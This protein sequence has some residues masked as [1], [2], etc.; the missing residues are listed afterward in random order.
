MTRTSICTGRLEPTGHD[1][2]LLESGQQLGLEVERQIAHLVEEQGAAVRRLQAADP[3]AARVGERALHMPEQLGFEE[4][5]GDRAQVDR[6]HDI[7]GAA[8]AAVKLARDELLAGAVLA[9][10]QDIGLGRPGPVDQRIDPA[11]RGGGA[12]Q[13]RLAARRRRGD[14]HRPLAL[15]RHRLARIAQRRGGADGGEQPLVRPGLGDEVGGAAL[16]RL[17]GD[18]DAAMG[19][20]H[21]HHRLRVALEDLAEPLEAFGGIGGAAA[22][23]GVEQDDIGAIAL[24]RGHCLLRRLKRRHVLEQVAQQQARRQQDVGIVV[25][26]DAAAECLA[27]PCHHRLPRRCLSR[28]SPGTKQLSCQTSPNPDIASVR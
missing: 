8:R 15:R 5:L 22:E 7:V 13:R 14:R 21:H 26:H 24:E 20:D 11:H 4:V 19:G 28:G 23:I 9:E 12:E 17:H 27:L 18:V 1:L 6:D 3:V 2:P 16:H 10:D 25:D